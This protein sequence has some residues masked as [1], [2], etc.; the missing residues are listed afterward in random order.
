MRYL[1]R[2]V[3]PSRYRL[4]MTTATRTTVDLVRLTLRDEEITLSL[5]P[6]IELRLI[7]DAAPDGRSFDVLT[8]PPPPE[9]RVALDLIPTTS[10]AVAQCESW[11]A[12]VG[13]QLGAEAGPL[14][15]L[16]EFSLEATLGGK[17]LP[18]SRVSVP[19]LTLTPGPPPRLDED[20]P[21][22]GVRVFTATAH[23]GSDGGKYLLHRP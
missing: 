15:T 10:D 6:G 4:L 8:L 13:A 11:A 1:A 22:P 17:G 19:R 2:A 23:T 20:E 21:L 7:I 14:G 5:A 12:R 18:Y 16:E 9:L 3:V